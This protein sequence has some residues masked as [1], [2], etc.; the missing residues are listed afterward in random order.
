MSDYSKLELAV[1][2][3]KKILDRLQDTDGLESCDDHLIETSII[4]IRKTL[5]KICGDK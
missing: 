2:A 4:T 5:E 1:M 3:L